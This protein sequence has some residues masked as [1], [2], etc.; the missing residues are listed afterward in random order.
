MS[1]LYS[2]AK[3]GKLKLKGEKKSSKEEEEEGR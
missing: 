3:G 2:I 1:G